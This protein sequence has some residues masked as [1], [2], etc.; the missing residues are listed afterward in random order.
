LSARRHS[1]AAKPARTVHHRP[2]W[3][4]EEPTTT[5]TDYALAALAGYFAAALWSEPGGPAA[6]LWGAAFAATAA[7]ALLGGT[8]HGFAPRLGERGKRALWRATLVTVGFTNLFLL[9]AAGTAAGGALRAVTHAVAGA[10]LLGYLALLRRRDDF[11]LAAADSGLS[12]AGVLLL[13]VHAL[14]AGERPWTPWI[15]AGVL[16]SLAAA[17][18]Q[19]TGRGPHRHLNHNDLFHLMQMGAA[20]LFYRG[21]SLL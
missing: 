11:A 20:Y 16:A 10:K 1:S 2:P 21:A 8:V 15:I 9:L 14:S 4:I 18:V 13:Q 6:A 19:R 3:R 17:G 12:L 5:L 7:A